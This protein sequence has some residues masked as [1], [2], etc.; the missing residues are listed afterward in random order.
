MGG[1][2]VNPPPHPPQFQSLLFISEVI[3]TATKARGKTSFLGSEEILHHK[4]SK[5]AAI[6][7]SCHS[8]ESFWCKI[9]SLVSFGL[10]AVFTWS[11]RFHLIRSL[12]SFRLAACPPVHPPACPTGVRAKRGSARNKRLALT[13][14]T[15]SF[16]SCA[17]PHLLV[18]SCC[19]CGGW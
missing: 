3:V 15:M 4:I 14:E 18:T 19:C 13:A 2:G 10:A 1:G 12:V 16:I 11:R 8:L 7:M 5:P 9:R 17:T 6:T